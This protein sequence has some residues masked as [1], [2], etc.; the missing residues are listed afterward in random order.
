MQNSPVGFYLNDELNTVDIWG[1]RMG[2]TKKFANVASHPHVA[3]V[4]D[5][6]ASVTPWIA[7]GIEIRGLAEP[8][9]DLDPPA[10]YYGREVIRISPYKI[11]TWGLVDGGA[12]TSRLVE[13]R[14]R[15]TEAPA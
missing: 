3:L 8:L 10:P 7:R 14:S 5:D 4:I 1:R 15:P 6:L 9:R 13:T 2:R 12:Y 11:I